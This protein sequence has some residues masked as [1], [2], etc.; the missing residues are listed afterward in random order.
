MPKAKG[1][2]RRRGGDGRSVRCPPRSGST[3]SLFED[4]LPAP[5]VVGGSGV[6]PYMLWAEATLKRVLIRPDGARSG[7]TLG[8]VPIPSLQDCH[9]V[10]TRKH[11]PRVTGVGGATCQRGIPM[12]FEDSPFYGLRVN[13]AKAHKGW[14]SAEGL[15][16][17]SKREFQDYL[18]SR[19]TYKCGFHSVQRPV[20]VNLDWLLVLL[21]ILSLLFK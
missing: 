19:R 21:T 2:Q 6:R 12:R 9:S 8:V 11:L 20:R 3:Y 15:D 13:Q 18:A 17:L 7:A 5:P 10:R 16:P 1:R 4:A 14:L